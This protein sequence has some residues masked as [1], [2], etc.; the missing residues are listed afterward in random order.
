VSDPVP[1][2]AEWRLDLHCH[3]H[4]SDGTLSPAELAEL[5]GRRQVRLLALTD[6]DS[7]LGCAEAQRACELECVGFV[8]GIELTCAWGEHELHVIGLNIDIDDPALRAH[9]E[10]LQRLRRARI[11]RIGA[12][13]TQARLPGETLAAEALRER[14]PTRT[15]LAR[16]LCAQGWAQTMNEAFER[17]LRRGRPGYAEGGWPDLGTT[18]RCIVAA[19]GVAVLAHPHHYRLSGRQLAELTGQFKAAGGQG[20]EV[21]M[22]GMSP[23]S[24][25]A[26]AR[27]AR[28]FDLAGSIGSDF[29]EP[30]LPWRPL[31]RFA[32]LPDA[33]RP[34][35]TQLKGVGFEPV[36]RN[37]RQGDERPTR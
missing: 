10:Q 16:A 15:H 22:A 26:A 37:G 23:T 36:S 31:G 1:D 3:S 7:V 2:S 19:G 24:I 32:K 8:P 18:V 20:L 25:A 4:Y 11:E 33:V 17:Y 34:I 35:T 30:G 28:R 21:S 9:C 12:R 6:H 13:L 14:C 5:A 29:H 27:L